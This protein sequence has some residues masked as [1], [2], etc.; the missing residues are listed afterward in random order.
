MD[1]PSAG[2][3][4]LRPFSD[5]DR[6]R[7]RRWLSDSHVIGWWGS[8]ATAEASIALAMHSP[9]AIV[10]I[11]ELNNEPIGYAHALDLQDSKLPAAVWHADIFIGS[12]MHQGH[13]IGITALKALTAELF[14]TTLA[15]GLSIRVPIKYERQVRLIERVGF[16]WHALEAASPIGPAWL[17]VAHRKQLPIQG[18]T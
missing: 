4:L 16:C 7:L 5:S 8:R 6:F 1:T 14:S 17:L 15:S 9:S 2:L 11:I 12:C 18:T 10:R 13:D 3:P